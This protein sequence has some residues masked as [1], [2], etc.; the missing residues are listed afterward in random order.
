MEEKNA[1]RKAA[2]KSR[3]KIEN[4]KEK[5]EQIAK[6]LIATKI[7]K[8]ADAIFAYM[9]YR[10]EVDTKSVILQALLDA[11]VVAL[12]RVIRQ[13]NTMVF[14]KIRS[15]SDCEAGSYGILEPK[16]DCPVI[17]PTH[18]NLILVPGCAFTRDGMRMG[19]GGGYYDRYLQAYSDAITVG[20]AFEEQLFEAIPC[21]IHD[22]Q[23]DF[24]VTQKL[25]FA[26]ADREMIEGKE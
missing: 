6:K 21:E 8:E 3:A 22:R 14:C 10:S 2:L 23:L 15:L 7:Y 24:V 25:C 17:E 4:R 20:Y 13:T 16:A 9:S 5:S 11:K 1:F 26:K 19:Y 12:P 18:K